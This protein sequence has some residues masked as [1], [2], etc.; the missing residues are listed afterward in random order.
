[1]TIPKPTF[2]DVL[3]MICIGIIIIWF[4]KGCRD[5]KTWEQAIIE[6]EAA[7][8]RSIDSSFVIMNKVE[9]EARQ[10]IQMW[11]DSAEA[12]YAEATVVRY[13]R[14][15]SWAALARSKKE[16][17]K[18]IGKIKEMNGANSLDCLELADRYV[19]ASGQVIFYKNKSDELVAKLDTAGKYKDEIIKEQKALTDKAIAVNMRSRAAYDSL[20]ASFKRI[21]NHAKFSGGFTAMGNKTNPISGAGIGGLFTQRNGNSIAIDAFM[22]RNANIYFQGTYYWRF[23]LRKD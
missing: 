7:R 11:Q 18:L 23:S 20:Y 8:K 21:G 5:K 12:N 22:M 3:L 2:R 17:D 16:T 9:A 4:W 14:D 10:K 1:M 19:D 13:E 15:Q 6:K